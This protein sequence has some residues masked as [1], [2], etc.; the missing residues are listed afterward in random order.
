MTASALHDAAIGYA[1]RGWPIFPCRANKTPYTTNGVLDATTNPDKIDEWWEKWPRANIGLDCAGAGFMVLDIDPGAAPDFHHSLTPQTG[2]SQNTPRGGKHLFYSLAEGEIVPPSVSKVA[3][4][5]DVRSF[6]SYVLLAPSRT[7]AGEYEWISE[8]KPAH[9]PQDIFEVATSS[10]RQKSSEHD[11]WLIEPDLDEN[12]ALAT[13]WLKKDAKI[14]VEGQGGDM[15]AYAT[16]AHLKSF[17]ISQA[18]ALDLMWEHWNPRCSPP[19]AGDE[20]DH[21]EQKVENGYRYNTSPPGNIT[22]AYAIARQQSMFKPVTR[23]LP[24]GQEISGG[25]FRV[26]DRDG[27]DHIKPPSWLIRDFIADESYA[28][29]FGAP[30][31]FKTFVALDAALSIATGGFTENGLWQSD[32]IASTGNVLMAIGEGRPQVAARIRAWEQ[33]HL[34]GQKARG[35]FLADPVPLVSEDWNP[36]FDT[37]L[38]ASPDGFRLVVIDTI[39]RSMQGLNENAQEHASKFTALVERIQA[40]TGAA[41]LAIHH[42]GQD[43]KERERGSSVFR[44]DSD[45]SVRVDRAG[46]DFEIELSMVK[47]KDAAEWLLPRE[48]RLAKVTLDDGVDSLAVERRPDEPDRKRSKEQAASKA[49]KAK[50]DAEIMSRLDDAVITVLK[51]NPTREWKTLDLAIEL[52]SGKAYAIDVDSKT[53]Q[54]THLVRLRENKESASNR[55]FNGKKGKGGRWRYQKPED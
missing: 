49:L 42:T 6:H 7:E 53:L 20:I 26:V 14:A 50:H 4:H 2:L 17:G 3:P 54:N 28:I 47:Q 55:C 43:H 48:A 13:A 39:G 24:S 23:E 11:T 9:R 18:L 19:W 37:I 35:I 33:R 38:A 34:Y 10:A 40:E 52:A 44:A 15:M 32:A 16:A 45:T 31:S 27:V 29:L 46:K 51:E 36:F 22:P 5:V 25:R 41:V 8:G 12:V 1:E 21:L 30:G